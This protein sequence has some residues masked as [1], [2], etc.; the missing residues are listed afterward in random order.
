[1]S[2][3]E[4]ITSTA[5]RYARRMAVRVAMGGVAAAAAGFRAFGGESPADAAEPREAP[6]ATTATAAA[7]DAAPA[8]APGAAPT[9]I[10]TVAST[11]SAAVAAAPSDSG[12]P[13]AGG[14]PAT[15][16]APADSA[17]A[18]DSGATPAALL[19]REAFTYAGQARR[20]PFASL[21]KAGGDLRPL[22]TDLRLVGVLVGAEGGNSVAIMRDLTTKEQYRRRTGE[23]LG[24]MRIARIESRQ[25]VFTIE[26]F[27]YSRQEVLT[28]GDSTT[29]RTK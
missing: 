1:M 23:A 11:D 20:D 6:P 3:R 9:T 10:H 7:P 16:V 4:T 5:Q 24:R 25:V 8:A 17:A 13:R 19:G 2:L 14:V 26:E 12:A 15:P 28:Y 21:L 27:G 29:M 18:V 22:I